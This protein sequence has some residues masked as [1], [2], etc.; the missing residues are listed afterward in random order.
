MAA[1]QE[2]DQSILRDR[3]TL[4]WTLD[5]PAVSF[6]CAVSTGRFQLSAGRAVRARLKN[7]TCM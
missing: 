5:P 6:I 2:L 1:S 3:L 7:V 4:V